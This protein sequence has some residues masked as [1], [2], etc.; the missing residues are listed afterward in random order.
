MLLDPSLLG[1]HSAIAAIIWKPSIAAIAEPFLS[2]IVAITCKPGLFGNDHGDGNENARKAMG[3]LNKTTTLHVITLF[4]TFCCHHYTT[5]TWKCL[6]SSFMKDVNKR[7]WVFLSLSKLVCDPQEI[8]SREIR[9]HF[10]FSA[11]WNKRNNV[12]IKV[13]AFSKWRFRWSPCRRWQIANEARSDELAITI[14][15]PT[16]ANGIIVLLNFFT[17][18]VIG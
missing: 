1:L 13:N 14:S 8:N 7:R 9:L 2:A 15:Y 4:C 10:T 5:T 6:I 18:S 17:T 11:D 12:W 3:L 16:S